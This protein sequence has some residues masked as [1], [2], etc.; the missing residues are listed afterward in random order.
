MNE[1]EDNTDHIPVLE[2]I[3]PDQ[4]HQVDSTDSQGTLE[5]AQAQITPGPTVDLYARQRSSRPDSCFH[6][7]IDRQYCVDDLEQCNVCGRV[8]FLN[9]FYRCIVDTSAF[10]EPFNPDRPIL[11]PWMAKAALDGHYT[12]E[13]LNVL[14]RQKLEVLEMAEKLRHPCSSPHPTEAEEAQ[15]QPDDDDDDSQVWVEDVNQDSS[16]SSPSTQAR[17][18]AIPRPPCTHH[19]CHHCHPALHQRCWLSIDAI[20]TDPEIKPFTEWDF[21]ERPMSDTRI[22]RTLGM[23]SFVTHS[24]PPSIYSLSEGDHFPGTTRPNPQHT[25]IVRLPRAVRADADAESSER[26]A[27]ETRDPESSIDATSAFVRGDFAS[28]SIV[29]AAESPTLSTAGLTGAETVL[30]TPA[31]VDG[32]SAVRELL[33]VAEWEHGG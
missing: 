13:E 10:T 8:P 17:V 18:H 14:F 3:P 15:E 31:V 7:V 28:S 27:P 23:R 25:P 5:T 11:S 12:D 33:A 30:E 22:V 24:A 1:A 32:F 19:A 6:S 29:E 2:G 16:R 20:C 26:T 21:H 9:W 4:P